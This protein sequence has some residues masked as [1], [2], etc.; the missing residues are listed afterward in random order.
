MELNALKKVWR[1]KRSIRMAGIAALTLGLAAFAAHRAGLRT[2]NKVLVEIENEAELHFVQEADVLQLLGEG[3][4]GPLIGSRSEALN[5]HAL[6]K[7]LL[8]NP[9]IE[10]AKVSRTLLGNLSV[11]VKQVNPIARLLCSSG[12][13]V[14][15]CDNGN[16]VPASKVFT[17]R[18]MVIDG[19]LCN[20]IARPDS[21]TRPIGDAA[22]ALA[23]YITDSE[24]WRPLIAQ[25]AAD[26]NGEYVLW[27]QIGRQKIY[28]GKAEDIE[29]KFSRLEAFYRKIVPAK[30]WDAYR[31]V[32]L[33]YSNQIICE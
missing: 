19:S 20:L 29:N 12:P 25:A 32:T 3:N 1:L 8:N 7:S 26:K 22:F 18:V 16:R 6:E 5:T 9:Y 21:A 28:F 13:D 10:E 31:K 17:P 30:G 2:C 14:Y 33:K 4:A 15:L 24:L 27:P 23:K 11:T